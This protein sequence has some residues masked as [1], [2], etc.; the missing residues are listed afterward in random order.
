LE[1]NNAESDIYKINASGGRRIQLTHNSKYDMYPSYS[2]NGK[3]MAY[4]ESRGNAIGGDI[5]KI[6][7]FAGGRT[8]LT[9]NTAD[10]A[11]PSWG[12]SP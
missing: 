3:K 7:A 1:R 12:S 6:N 9:H 5:Y 2:P 8:K 10:E 11:A 4:T